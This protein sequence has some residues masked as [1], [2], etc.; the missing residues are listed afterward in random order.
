MSEKKS[1]RW[2]AGTSGNPRGR[3]VGQGTVGKLRTSIERHVPAI[4]EA[5]AVLA[6]SGDPQSA[7]LLLERVV[8]PVKAVE[9]AVILKLPK[10]GTLTEKAEAVL[11]AAADGTLAPTQAA[12]LLT[13]LATLAKVSE[14]DELAAR[15]AKLEEQ[16]HGAP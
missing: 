10:D 13:A 2:A 3:A 4:L 12:Q 14:I 9:Q 11:A 8:P 7:R 15:I 16:H 1:G 5:L 6:K